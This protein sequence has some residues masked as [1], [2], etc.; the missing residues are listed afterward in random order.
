MHTHLHTYI[1]PIAH[2]AHAL[3]GEELEEDG[4]RDAAVED[5]GPLHALHH[6]GLGHLHLGEED[7]QARTESSCGGS[8]C[9]LERG[10][11]CCCWDPRGGGRR[12]HKHAGG[13]TDTHLG[14]HAARDGAVRL[15]LLHLAEAEAREER[16]GLV[17]HA[18]HVRQEEEALGA[19][20]AGGFG[21]TG[22]IVCV[23]W[24]GEEERRRRLKGGSGAERARTGARP[25]RCRRPCR[26]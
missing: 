16:L 2:P 20:R 26:R 13:H 9:W 18:G 17:E 8:V 10:C 21:G 1:N 24:G 12:K 14:D 15:E 22:V 7:G 4:V 6:R 11:C 5:D 25:P 3:V 19:G 23:L